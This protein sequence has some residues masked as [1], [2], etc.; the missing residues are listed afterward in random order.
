VQ[1]A[2]KLTKKVEVHMNDGTPMYKATVVNEPV[3]IKTH[4]QM[5]DKEG[6]VRLHLPGY[7]SMRVA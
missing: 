5:W 1:L 2:N 6:K 4:T 7:I 3:A